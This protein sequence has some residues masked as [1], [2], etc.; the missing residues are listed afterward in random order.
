[1]RMADTHS[2]LRVSSCVTTWP[3]SCALNCVEWTNHDLAGQAWLQE[4]QHRVRQSTI[5][6]LRTLC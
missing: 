4:R 6:G 3:E 1:M 5:E 2:F